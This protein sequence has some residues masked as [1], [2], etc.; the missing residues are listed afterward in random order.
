[1]LNSDEKTLAAEEALELRSLRPQ[2]QVPY[3]Y[4]AALYSAA[5][6][7]LKLFE[8]NINCES[9]RTRAH[10]HS[11]H[12]VFVKRS[13]FIQFV[14]RE[15][16]TTTFRQIR[17]TT[18]PPTIQLPKNDPPPFLPSFLCDDGW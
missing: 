3:A 18:D 16:L 6:I 4:P 15:L 2:H 11:S 17:V 14:R 10:S 9:P 1:M 5:Q 13:T 7:Y 8:I 12:D